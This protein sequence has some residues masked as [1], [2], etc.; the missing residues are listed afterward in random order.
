MN[1]VVSHPLFKGLASCMAVLMCLVSFV[2]RVQAGFVPSHRSLSADVRADDLATVQ[3]TLENKVVRERLADLGYSP[4]EV[5]QRLA[6]L[7]DRELHT[8]ASQLE[9]LDAGAGA[10]GVIIAIVII[11]ILGFVIWYIYDDEFRVN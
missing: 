9:A 4:G 6:A 3:Q 8:L 7:S 5:E 1:A 10:G 2:P 11:A